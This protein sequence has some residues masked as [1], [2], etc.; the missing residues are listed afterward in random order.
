MAD[1]GVEIPVI[2]DIDKAFQDAANRVPTAMKIM[3]ARVDE[4]VLEVPVEI[5]KKGDLAEVLDFVGETQMSLDNLKYAIKSTASELARLKRKGAS[6]ED[7]ETY[8]KAVILLKAIREEWKMQ[9]KSAMQIGDAQ[10]RNLEIQQQYNAVLK[11]TSN[12]IDDVNSKIA[13]YTAMLNSSDVGSKQFEEAAKNVGIMSRRLEE[14]QSWA[15][16][17][18]MEK[19][20]LDRY[21]ANLQE[22]E[23]KF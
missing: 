8:E 12:T 3:Q 4:N 23:R 18:G 19:W 16:R 13:G 10:F 22:I 14:L 1:N 17:L 21:N 7:I 6:T 2:I 5:N 11:L 15:R 20:S 9:E